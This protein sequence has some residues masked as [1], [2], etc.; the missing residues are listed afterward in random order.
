MLSS[1][2]RFLTFTKAILTQELARAVDE[3]NVETTLDKTM[4]V[5]KERNQDV[6]VHHGDIGD[7]VD[8]QKVSMLDKVKNHLNETMISHKEDRAEKRHWNGSRTES[9]SSVKADEGSIKQIPREHSTQ[10]ELDLINK[11]LANNYNYY[12][13]GFGKRNFPEVESLGSALRGKKHNGRTKENR[14]NHR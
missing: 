11:K 8:W 10:A 7:E 4:T 5:A 12:G 14:S 13:P 9:N 3:T 6:N 1:G 2:S